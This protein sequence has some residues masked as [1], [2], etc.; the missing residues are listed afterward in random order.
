MKVRLNGREL[1]PGEPLASLTGLSAVTR[2]LRLRCSPE[3]VLDGV[4]TVTLEQLR[5]E[6]VQEVS[7]VEIRMNTD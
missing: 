6:A 5:P 7:W 2:A 3:A 1:P 4:N